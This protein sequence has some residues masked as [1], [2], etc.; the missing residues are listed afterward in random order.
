[1]VDEPW[2]AVFGLYREIGGASFSFRGLR[3][4]GHS[5]RAVDV[6]VVTVVRHLETG[7]EFVFAK[8]KKARRGDEGAG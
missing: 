8:K 1:L 5:G 6:H 2:E 3:N 7:V 4:G